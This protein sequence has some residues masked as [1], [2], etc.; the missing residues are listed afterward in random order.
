MNDIETI[1][2]LQQ[3]VTKLENEMRFQEREAVEIALGVMIRRR[4][5]STTDLHQNIFEIAKFQ[6]EQYKMGLM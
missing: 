5:P 4:H 3:L 2:I 6:S 1:D